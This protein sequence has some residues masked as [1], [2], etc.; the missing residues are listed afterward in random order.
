MRDPHEDGTAIGEQ[1]VDPVGDCHAD[2]IGAKVV[3]VDRYWQAVPFGASVLEVADQFALLG[4]DTD[5]GQSALL[6]AASRLRNEIELLVALGAL[7]GRERLAI[8]A[9][10]VVHALE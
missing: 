3:V 5:H 10:G 9:Q 1:I 6:E 8:D 4:V 7:P 2:R